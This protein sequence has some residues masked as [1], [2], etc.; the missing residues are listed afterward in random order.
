MTVTSAEHFWSIRLHVYSPSSWTDVL[1][2]NNFLTVPSLTNSN[3]SLLGPKG[4][5]SLNHLTSAVADVTS[6]SKMATSRSFTSQSCNFFTNSGFV[7]V[8]LNFNYLR[9]ILFLQRIAVKSIVIFSFNN[10]HGFI[11][12]LYRLCNHEFMENLKMRKMHRLH[13]TRE[14]I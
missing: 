12:F 10:R 7:A 2:M 4:S 11:H 3:F 1:L 13:I 8:I 6:T 14:S 9:V 5:P